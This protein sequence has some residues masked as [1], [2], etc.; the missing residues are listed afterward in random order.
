MKRPTGESEREVNLVGRLRFAGGSRALSGEVRGRCPAGCGGA[1]RRGRVA[2]R[3]G[4]PG[5]VRGCRGRGAGC[6][7]CGGTGGVPRPG[8]GSPGW[9]CSLGAGEPRRSRATCVVA[10]GAML[11]ATPLLTSDDHRVLDEIE[12]F[13]TELRRLLAQPCRWE[14]S[15]P[16]VPH[17]A[18]VRGPAGRR[19][20]GQR[21]VVCSA[22]RSA[23]TSSWSRGCVRR[24]RAAGGVSQ[25]IRSTSVFGRERA[26]RRLRAAQ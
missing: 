2:V 11:F 13:R 9:I 7:G 3:R 26:A 10:C 21:Y 8:R 18:A 12:A 22:F 16:P 17:A 15:A 6:G 4:R 1:V 14:R 23:S 19:R 5:R 20:E 25:A 24:V